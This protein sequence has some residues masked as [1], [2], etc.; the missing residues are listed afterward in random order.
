M[1][2][3]EASMVNTGLDGIQAVSL[4]CRSWGCPLCN[5]ARKSQLVALA[6]SGDP[7]TFI[8]LTVTPRFGSSPYDRARRLADA[9]REIIRLAKARY[10]YRTIPYLCVFEATKKGEPHLHILCRVKWIGQK[11]LSDQ[12][13]RL[14]MAPRVDIRRVHNK[15]K[16]AFYISKYIGK[17]PHR[18]QSCKR[19][20]TTRNYELTKF[21]PTKPD[22]RWDQCW[23]LVRTPLA[24]LAEE[25]RQQGRE[26]ELGRHRILCSWHGPPDDVW[27]E[28]EY[29]TVRR[30]MGKSW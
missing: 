4:R 22:G 17:D 16:L 1:L 19:Y 14:M 8:T 28:V 6:K 23:K 25:W 24:A 27:A 26:V 3:S 2:C 10:G 21:E 11:W 18:F 29:I 30:R 20:W 9:W 13:K 15:K 12:M 7:N 5:A